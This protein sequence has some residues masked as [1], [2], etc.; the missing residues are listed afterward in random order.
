[1]KA[2][3]IALPVALAAFLAVFML[4]LPARS[5]WCMDEANRFLQTHA[6]TLDEAALPPALPYPGRELISDAALL[7]RLRPLPAQYG[8]MR[9]GN[10]Y[11]QYT[12][13]LALITAPFYGIFGQRGILLPPIAGGLAL[14]LVLAGMLHTRGIA[15]RT[16]LLLAFLATPIP[17]YSLT[18]FSHS[19]A[20]LLAM[21]SLLLLRG[22]RVIPAFIAATLAVSMRIEMLF[23]FPL[24][25]LQTEGRPSFGRILSAA[26]LSAALFLAAIR[27]N[28]CHVCCWHRLG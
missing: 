27:G 24:L 11:S 9:D 7:E 22:N 2:G 13:I 21:A 5:F 15:R 1:M 19:L 12:P 3:R 28:V 4:A 17:F 6:L 26:I 23:A 8:F 25:L 14:A 10:L 16:G 18:F 20:L